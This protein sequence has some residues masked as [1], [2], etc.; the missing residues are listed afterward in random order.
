[1]R[2][3]IACNQKME[4]FH[5]LI[6]AQAQLESYQEGKHILFHHIMWLLELC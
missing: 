1:M 6:H 4:K 3:K 2:W 5:D